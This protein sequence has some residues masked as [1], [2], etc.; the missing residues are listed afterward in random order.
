MTITPTG[1]F[2]RTEQG[3]DLILE[4]TFN[5]P[6]EDVWA[7]ITESDRLGRWFGTWKGEAEAGKRVE[8]SFTAEEGSQTSDVL[9]TVC[10]PPHHL[11][12]SSTDSFGT[13][14]LEAH[15]HED[16]GST[17][18]VFVQ[19]LTSPTQIAD[20]G[21]GWEYYLDRLVAV[22]RDAPMPEWDAYLAELK[23][24]YDDAAAVT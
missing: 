16:E 2:V 14:H 13:W 8:L 9:I 23:P 4:R 21:P 1:R 10:E 17:Q 3:V 5:A 15:L 18:L 19:H 6:M 24:F 12:V 11:A 22:R 20:T 7:S